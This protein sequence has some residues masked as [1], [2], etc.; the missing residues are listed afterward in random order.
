MK[1]KSDYMLCEIA[2]EQIVVP[3][4]AASSDFHGMLRLNKTGTALWKMLERGA[5]ME[6]LVQM[7]VKG[8]DAPESDAKNDAAEFVEKLRKIGC[9]E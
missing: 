3:Y 8:F 4:G 5:E 6:A 7:L 2:G 1:I 9:L